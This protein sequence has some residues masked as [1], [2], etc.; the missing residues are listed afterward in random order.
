[1][2]DNIILRSVTGQIHI[3]ADNVYVMDLYNIAANFVVDDTSDYSLRSTIKEVESIL[4]LID[5]DINEATNIYSNSV[6]R[7]SPYSPKL[8]EWSLAWAIGMVAS[9]VPATIKRFFNGITL[10]SLSRFVNMSSLMKYVQKYRRD[11]GEKE[12]QSTLRTEEE[13]ARNTPV[14]RIEY[15]ASSCSRKVRSSQRSANDY[16]ER[17]EKLNSTIQEEYQNTMDLIAKDAKDAIT[18]LSDKLEKSNREL[19]KTKA[20][21]IKE[22]K[23]LKELKSKEHQ[24]EVGEQYLIQVFDKY[25]TKYEK[26]NDLQLRKEKY[27]ELW[28][29]VSSVKAIPDSIKERV[30]AL[31]F[32]R[33]D[34]LEK[35]RQAALSTQGD[36]NGIMANVVKVEVGKDGMED[37]IGQL[38]KTN[39]IG[40]DDNNKRRQ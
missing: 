18:D 31:E 5:M 26:S 7:Y 38:I 36:N 24:K 25:I 16:Q 19:E 17:L 10:D 2:N 14:K 37:Y 3:Q 6:R 34:E 30:A 9:H 40:D 22:E 29:F 13:P 21:L 1:M 33:E 32:A 23:E 20:E 28:P 39:L 35:E 12:A 11:M 4:T 15:M 8:M 27:H